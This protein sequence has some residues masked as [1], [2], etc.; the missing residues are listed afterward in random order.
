MVADALH[1][2]EHALLLVGNGEPADVFAL[3]RTASAAGIVPAAGVDAGGLEAAAQQLAHD[4]VG[5]GFHAAVGVV[6]DEPLAGAQQLVGDDQ[7]ADGVVAGAAAGIA[8]DVGV[9]LGEAGVLGRVEAGVHAGEDGEMP[10]RGHRQLAL[11][12]KIGRVGLVG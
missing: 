2:L 7:R 11:V 10:A 12:A 3:W 1:V 6:D 8:D 5:E 4:V 9:A